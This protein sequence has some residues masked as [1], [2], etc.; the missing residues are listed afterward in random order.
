VRY[1]LCRFAV[2]GSLCSGVARA[3]SAEDSA[4]IVH[5]GITAIIRQSATRPIVTGDTFVGWWP[6]PVLYNTVRRSPQKVESSFVRP[7]GLIGTAEARWR[8]GRQRTIKI[9]WT[10]GD[11]TLLQ[12][13]GQS[14]NGL[15]RLRGGPDTVVALPSLPW[16]IADYGMDDQMLPLI[17]H[18]GSQP[19]SRPVVVFRPFAQR[20]DTVA[21][22]VIRKK[23]AI[24]AAIEN[25][26]GDTDHWVITL[27]GALVRVTR[28][29][30]PELERR[31]LEQTARMADYHRLRDAAAGKP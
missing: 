21:I 10:E 4:R 9:L 27:D 2:A 5:D 25:G 11:S 31:P 26:P 19:R 14:G 29:R 18:L 30:Y 16:V 7:D 24:I 12:L 6:R 1:S 20:W 13:Q 8:G 17:E 28:D 3:Q 22:T 15:L 23:E